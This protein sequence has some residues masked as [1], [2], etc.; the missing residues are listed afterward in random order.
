MTD[1]SICCEKFNKSNRCKINCKTCEDDQVIACQS[2]AKRYILDQPTDPSCMICKVEWDTEFLT[3]NFTKT[4]ISKE[5]KFHRENYLLDKQIALLPETQEYAE[6]LKL[7]DGLENQ[8][9]II[10]EERIKLELKL[11][12]LNSSIREIDNLSLIHI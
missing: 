5:L 8:K 3:D 2:C 10:F 1:C 6:Q 4:F 9:N 7:I 12:K 11:R